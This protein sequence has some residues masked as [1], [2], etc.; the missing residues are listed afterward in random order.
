MIEFYPRDIGLWRGVFDFTTA[1]HPSMNFFDKEDLILF[2]KQHFELSIEEENKY[3]V[4]F[5]EENNYHLNTTHI[6]HRWT[7]V[8]WMKELIGEK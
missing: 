3:P 8:G 5:I 2:V 6:V 7:V 1:A 4:T